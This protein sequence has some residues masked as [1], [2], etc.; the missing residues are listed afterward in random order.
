ML[1]MCFAVWKNELLTKQF[2][3]T[4]LRKGNNIYSYK[5]FTPTELPKVLSGL[6]VCSN[7]KHR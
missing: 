3:P 4:E 2:A 5:H 6:T 7:N 1:A